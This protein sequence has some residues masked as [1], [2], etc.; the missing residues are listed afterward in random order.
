MAMNLSPLYKQTVEAIHKATA[1]EACSLAEQLCAEQ[2]QEYDS[3]QMAGIAALSGG[4][5]TLALKHFFAAAELTKSPGCLAATW[6]GIGRVYLDLAHHVK[7][8]VAFLRAI[9]LAPEFPPAFPGLAE[10]LNFLSQYKEAEIAARKAIDLGVTD[11]RTYSTLA[12]ACLRLKKLEEAEANYRL[13]LHRDSNSVEAHYGLGIIA[14]IYGHF[15]ES[16]KYFRAISGKDASSPGWVQLAGLKRFHDA[17]DPDLTVMEGHFAD[18]QTS[19]DIKAGLAFALAKAYDDLGDTKRAA[20]YLLQGNRYDSETRFSDYDSQSDKRRMERIS[21]LFTRDFIER[22]AI[23]D[24]TELRPIFV[25]GL[26]RSGS[27]LTE[28][29]IGMYPD[30]MPG[31]ELGYLSKIITELSLKW[32]SDTDFPKLS[33]DAARHDLR[34]AAAR[35]VH[36]TARLRLIHS[37]F[38]DK[39]LENFLYIG[40]IRMMFPNARVVHVRRHPLATALGIFRRRFSRGIPYS[41]DL[42]QITNFYRSYTHLMAHWKSTTPDNFYDLFYESLVLD[43]ESELYGLLGYLGLNY[44]A[45]VL[46]YYKLVRPVETASDVQVRQPLN[47]DGLERHN[48]YL[49]MLRPVAEVLEEEISTYERDLSIR[50]EEIK[51]NRPTG[52]P[53]FNL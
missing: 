15:D 27:T 45:R 32:G 44:D 22:Y 46:E 31:G 23:E 12:F 50:L 36:E 43:T 34:K 40:A 26:P 1:A 8:K 20:N 7:A 35:Y 11:S 13:V 28:Q 29:I 52:T 38:T 41:A 25:V 48:K 9:S 2:P 17:T 49:E 42:I 4:R 33:V 30:V 6:S 14:R 53:G 39:S 19:P 16:Q 51:K 21:D 37:R 24:E 10:A 18:E 3:E 5:Y 47:L